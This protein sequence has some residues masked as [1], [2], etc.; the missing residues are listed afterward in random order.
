MAR[1]ETG[2]RLVEY[3]FND[4]LFEVSDNG[5]DYYTVRAPGN[6]SATPGTATPTSQNIPGHATQQVIP[7]REGDTLSWSDGVLVRGADGTEIVMAAAK[8]TKSLWYRMRFGG[9]NH[10]STVK[11]ARA[12][13][14]NAGGANNWIDIDHDTGLLTAGS[15]ILGVGK[16]VDLGTI[17]VGQALEYATAKDASDE[18]GAG[19][20]VFIVSDYDGSGLWITLKNEFQEDADADLVKSFRGSADVASAAGSYLWVTV[21]TNTFLYTLTPTSEPMPSGS[22]DGSLQTSY[23]FS[24]STRRFMLESAFTN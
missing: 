1:G 15:D 3:P 12:L 6:L 23:D 14:A 11:T 7:A 8:H 13:A 22:T 16:P 4:T 17:K 9:R 18:P 20:Q 21:P 2:K 5:T 19:H 24:V 10:R